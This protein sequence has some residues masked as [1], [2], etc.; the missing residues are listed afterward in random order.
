VLVG[1]DGRR[2]VVI[3]A[4]KAAQ[5]AG[6][7]RGM[8]ATKAQVLVPSLLVEKADHDSD[9]HALER[10]A[11]WA[12]RYSP[13]AAADPPDGIA[14]DIEGASHLLGG[15][16]ELLGDIASRLGVAGFDARV[17]VADSWGAAHAVA[18]HGR[19]SVAVVERGHCR[20]V[21]DTLPLTCLRLESEIAAALFA[22]G[23]ETVGDLL[24]QPRAPLV[25]RF[26][27]ELG[28]RLDQ[29]V[30]VVAEP[31]DPVRPHD[32]VEVRQL[33]AEPIG[34][35][36]TIKRYIAKLVGKLCL[37]LE[38][39][40][41][42]ARRLD[43]LCHRVDANF[44]SVRVGTALPVR[45]T[46][47]LAR[48]LSDKVET[49][50]PGY[51]I[52][53]MTLAATLAEPLEAKQQRSSLIDDAVPDV[54][55]LVDVL[56]NRIGADRLYRIEPVASDVPERSVKRVPAAAPDSEETWSANWP[57]P[58]RLLAKPEPIDTVALLPDHPPASFTWRGIRRRVRRAD[59]PER[60]FGE[61]WKRDAELTAV[62]DY[63]RVEDEAGERFWIY[64]A[65]DGKD[66]STGSQC[67]FLHGI[68]G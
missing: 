62:R 65:G 37:E 40:G 38:G 26:G 4:D 33:F 59:G 30:G 9:T 13:I 41:L 68:F 46:K 50:D 8:P 39:R 47:R 31:I 43:L 20:G 67:W 60:V 16:Q 54:S 6:V 36:E 52:E 35:A 23:F 66:A 15:E 2:R 3:A 28:R 42:G 34:S 56:S 53:I 29:L 12:L 21:V 14:I 32:V 17:A 58:A 55:D 10:L 22:L 45:D 61:W 18:R 5:R 49:I 44:Q 7:R 27:Q 19:D 48:L 64:R 63:F 11:F 24:T 1:T 25:L 57:R 51:G